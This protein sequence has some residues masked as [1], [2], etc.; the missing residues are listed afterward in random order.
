MGGH[1]LGVESSC[2]WATPTKMK[3]KS[4]PQVEAARRQLFTID[5]S[6]EMG[7]FFDYE[8]APRPHSRKNSPGEVRVVSP[9]PKFEDAPA[10]FDVRNIDGENYASPDRNQHIPQ[11]C[12]SCW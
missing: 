3:A 6:I 9:L 1:N 10:S 8:N 12:G 11:Y 5:E 2:S 4:K 7:T